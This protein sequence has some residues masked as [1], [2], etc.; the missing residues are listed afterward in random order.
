MSSHDLQEPLRKI[1]SFALRILDKE[2]DNLS[3]TGKDYF[4]RMQLA[5]QRMQ[6]LIEDLLLY[7]RTSTSERK[8]ED[9]D[10]QKLWMK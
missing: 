9:T 6:Q 3:E 1:H 2:N 4:R 5:A 8:F 10:L 7:S